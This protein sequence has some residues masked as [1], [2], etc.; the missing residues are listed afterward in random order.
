MIHIQVIGAGCPKCA[1]LA[2][3]VADAAQRL[4]VSCRLEKV[5]GLREIVK[6]GFPV[7]A[8]VIGGV[9]KT[10]GLVPTVTEIQEMVRGCIAGAPS[11]VPE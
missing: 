5:T 3:R 6:A 10:A 9:V 2:R 11:A 7:P 8:L 4:G 1:K